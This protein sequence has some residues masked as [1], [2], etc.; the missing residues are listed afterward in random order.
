MKIASHVVQ[1]HGNTNRSTTMKVKRESGQVILEGSASENRNLIASGLDQL[2]RGRA[3]VEMNGAAMEALMDDLERG[4]NEGVAAGGQGEGR[5]VRA[6][7]TNRVNPFSEIAQRAMHTDFRLTMLVKLLEAF[8]GRRLETGQSFM[9]RLMQNNPN[10][11][12]VQDVQRAV[13]P[14]Q[15]AQGVEQVFTVVTFDRIEKVLHHKESVSFSVTAHVTT[16]CG[17]V[18]DLEMAMNMSR[19][20]YE[21]FDVARVSVY[22]FIDPLVI[23]FGAA[24]AQLSDRK[25]S[26]DLDANGEKNQISTLKPGSGWL[27]IDNGRGYVADGSQLF[28]ALTGCGFSELAVHDTDGNGWID[29]NDDIWDCLRIWIQ[30]ED[31][32]SRLVGLGEKGIGA[33]FLGSV[34]TDF[35]MRGESD[36]VN[37]MLRRTGFFL[38]NDGRGA[39]TVQHVD[40][41]V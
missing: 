1:M 22:E 28:G 13:L 6:E 5:E 21:R 17:K 27:A 9:D 35:T 30:Y 23:N 36:E 11:Q 8:T 16:E 38:F 24:Y 33:I 18:I 12:S 2:K 14:Q 32:T 25:I 10:L 37:G 29:A 31:G 26:F 20:L 7:R 39:G 15:V 41:R 40:L 3:S 19:E 4:D 34:E